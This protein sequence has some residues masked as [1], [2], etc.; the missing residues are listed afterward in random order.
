MPKHV[1]EKSLMWACGGGGF[2]IIDQ[3]IPGDNVIDSS[4]N[5]EYR[6][7]SNKRYFYGE[8]TPPEPQQKILI[9]HHWPTDIL[10]DIIVEK[11]IVIK[12][13]FTT[14]FLL[15]I[16]RM[17]AR[18]DSM[19]TTMWMIGMANVISNKKLVEWQNFN[20]ATML[21]NFVNN[22][23]IFNYS[24]DPISKQVNNMMY[25]FFVY[26]KTR[27][28]ECKRFIGTRDIFADFIEY[29]Y[30]AH[31]YFESEAHASLLTNSSHPNI[32]SID[33]LE[34]EEAFDTDY[35]MFGVNN[36][37]KQDYSTKNKNLIKEML[38][39]KDIGNKLLTY[40]V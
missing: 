38:S 19:A 30:K 28:Y 37:I 23:N 40:D 33:I 10:D 22:S 25:L 13:S 3:L 5:N 29:M 21:D 18:P 17:L 20:E 39:I 8:S 4:I 9:G 36:E 31:S 15:F 7:I 24:Q 11:M 1:F 26:C 12:P 35:D 14:N 2:F 34:Y 32:K 6:T 16:K 27:Q